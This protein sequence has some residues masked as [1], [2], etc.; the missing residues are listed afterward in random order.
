MVDQNSVLQ[1]LR[2]RFDVL[3]GLRVPLQ[4]GIG[5]GLH[6]APFLTLLH[7]LDIRLELLDFFQ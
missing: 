7:Q 1:W 5:V 4:V 6:K 3:V 2:L